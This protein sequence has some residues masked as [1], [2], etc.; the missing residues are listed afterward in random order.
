MTWIE[1]ALVV[2]TVTG[3]AAT[4]WG[5]ARH[6]RTVAV[7]A[8]ALASASFVLFGALSLDLGL[9]F[10]ACLLAGLVLCLVGDV[11]LAVPGWFRAGLG[12]FLAG[13]LAY[14]AGFASRRPPAAWPLA[15]LAILAPVVAVVLVWL[16]PRLGRLRWPVVVYV[17]AIA[18][19]VWGAFGLAA[20][21]AGP[22]RLALGA[23]AFFGS[24]LAVARDRFVAPG[25]GNRL[26]GLPL[27]Y[28]GQLLIASSGP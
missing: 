26:W 16:W 2:T 9:R 4:L 28:L 18:A 13:H 14:L 20:S 25:L 7:I 12:A 23:A 10:G 5:E 1:V 8:K 22:W 15:P 27:Y 19:M 21:G 17:V 11:C 3:V 24:D 6:R